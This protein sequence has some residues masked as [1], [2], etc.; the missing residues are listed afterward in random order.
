[1]DSAPW[2]NPESHRE[3]QK[4]PAGKLATHEHLCNA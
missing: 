1:M 2:W 3:R 4:R